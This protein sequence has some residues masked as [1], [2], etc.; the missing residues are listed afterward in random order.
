[1]FGDTSEDP[2][3]IMASVREE[4]PKCMWKPNADQSTNIGDFQSVVNQTFG[5]SLGEY[6]SHFKVRSCNVAEIMKITPFVLTGK[7]VELNS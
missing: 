6:R 5:L 7:F 4:R 1:M 3:S 2:N